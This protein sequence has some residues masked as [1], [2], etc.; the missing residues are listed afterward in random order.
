M[1]HLREQLRQNGLPVNNA[2]LEVKVVPDQQFQLLPHLRSPHQTRKLQ[3]EEGDIKNV[4]QAY[5][6]LNQIVIENEG[7]VAYVYFEDVID[8]FLAKMRLDMMK[9][10]R[11]NATLH[12]KFHVPPAQKSIPNPEQPQVSSD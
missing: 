11:D 12:V 1:E 3:L 2:C 7:C 8:A 4:F 10:A 9:L 5:G 6:K